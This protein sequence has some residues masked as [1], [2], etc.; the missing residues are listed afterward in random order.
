MSRKIKFRVWNKRD[1]GNM[2]GPREY[3]GWDDVLTPL[4]FMAIYKSNINHDYFGLNFSEYFENYC[5]DNF[6][7]M[8]YTGLK[9]KNNKEIY[10][11]DILLHRWS[12][13]DSFVAVEW[14]NNYNG[15]MDCP[16]LSDRWVY[17]YLEVNNYYPLY[18]YRANKMEIIGN[19]LENN[20]M[21]L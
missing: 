4:D 12:G 18:T 7:V 19:I 1:G 2:I 13:E 20:N 3:L 21:L 6:V 15:E 11:G 10:E 8:Q 9:D 5:K 16:I 17:R 14:M